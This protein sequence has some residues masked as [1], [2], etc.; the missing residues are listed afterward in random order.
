MSNT[1]DER[2]VQMKFNNG[3]FLNG[4]KSTLAGLAGLKKGLN[5]D[6]ATKGLDNLNAAGKRF[7]LAGL[8][9]GIEN[10][11]SKFSALSVVGIT[12]LATIANKAVNVGAQ[13]TK[14][15]TVKP[16]T[17]GLAEYETNLN[18]IQTIL[19]NTQA[20]GSTLADVNG[21]LAELN[22]YSDQTIYNF[23]EMAKNIGTFTAAGVDLDTST[24]AIKGIANLAALSGSNSNQAS[25]A[26]YQLSQELANGK[27]TLLGWTSVVNAGMGGTVFQRA[28]AET[29]VAMGTIDK[30]ALSLEGKMKNV[31]IEGKSFR[32]S[33]SAENGESWLTSE[34]LTQ[35]LQ[36]FTGDLSDAELAAE[37]FSASQ[38]EAI[39][40]QAK[41]AKEAATVVK[42]S[43]QLMGTLAE[44]AGS[45]W[46][47]SWQII[48]GDFEE[49]K[50]L[51][52]GVN[53]VLGEMIGKSADARNATL[54]DWKDSG[55]RD[56]AINAV[57]NAFKALM[58]VFTPIKEAFREIFP[59]TTG[60]QLANITK[61]I[62]NFTKGLIIGSEASDKL[63]RTFKGLFAILDIVKTVVFGLVSVFFEMLGVAT[64]GSGGILDFTAKIG[65][66]LVKVRDA[67]KEGDGLVTFFNTLRDV[68]RKPIEFI[69]QFATSLVELVSGFEGF[70][71][72]GVEDG[73][74]RISARFDVMSN[75]GRI[76]KGLW[77]K[78]QAA[79]KSARDFFTPITD[80]MMA[81]F[82]DIGQQIADAFGEVDF[83]TVLD[84]INTGLLAGIVLLI[85]KFLKGGFKSDE[86]GG[87]FD[88][89]KEA[90]GSLT[91]TLSAMQT[92]LK[93]ATLLAIAAAVALLTASVVAL[94][95]IDSA[96]LTK[97]LAAI[98]VMFVQ[99]LVGMGFLDAIAASS[100]FL[101]LPFIA[102]S[103][104]LLATAVLVL[105]AA[106]K[107]LSDLD[108][109]GLIKGLVG[110]SVLLVAV[111]GASKIMSGN[112]GGMISAGVG[113]IAVAAAIKI[114]ASA[115]KDFSALSWEDMA[116]GLV[117][118]GTVLTALTL[119]T[120]LAAVNKGAVASSVGLIL[121]GGALKVMAS[122][123]KDFAEMDVAS[124]TKGLVSVT[125]ILA[126]IA[127]FTKVTSG[128]ISMIATAAGVAILGGALKILASAVSDFADMSWADLGKGMAGM[129]A[130][131]LAI[132]GA[133]WLMP[134]NMIVT[135][136][137]LVIVAAALTTLSE[138]LT[139]MGGMSWEE[140]AKGLVTL[141]GSLLI[142]AG[143]MFLMTT[144]LPGALAL[145]VIAGALSLL[146]PV[147]ISL[148][149]MTWGEIVRG[150]VTLA[151]ALAII[152]LA[153]LLLTPVIPS[154]MGLGVAMAL[155][156]VGALGV[157]LGLVAFSAGLT[158]LALSGAV[159]TTVLVAMVSALLGLI[160]VAMTQFGLGVIALAGVITTGAPAIVGALVAVLTS[161]I[162]AILT[163]APMIIGALVTLIFMLIDTLVSNVPR[164]VAAGFELLLGILRGIGDN[165]GL[166][167][168]EAANIIVQ[169]INGISNN[170]PSITEA[171]A[172][173]II[174][175]VESLATSV[176]NNSSRMNA[177]GLD[178]AGAI[179]EG[180]TSGIAN[181]IAS[182]AQAARDMA[183]NAL[184]AAMDFLDI[185]SPSKKFIK[186]G[187]STGE[188][189]V[190]GIVAMTGVV[191]KASSDM[192]ATSLDGIKNSM[193]N[194]A[195]AVEGDLSLMP[196]VR[197]VLDLSNIR[198]GSNLINGMLVPDTLA[199]DKAYAKAAVLSTSRRAIDERATAAKA[200]QPVIPSITLNQTNTSP[201]ALSEIDIYRRTNN[202]LS[203]V[204]EVIDSHA[205]QS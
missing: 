60:A 122:S 44:A 52:T 168:D 90:F 181:G 106:V 42:T 37:G 1:I 135:A 125:A 196:T 124:L 203:T 38:I 21:K 87:F 57:A 101:K 201:K 32:D 72:G 177:A 204:K 197:P 69:R 59:A 139:S 143:A 138:V 76:A 205:R 35:T 94:S 88:S 47:A 169:F 95:F 12:A 5:L 93:S 150:L 36:Q 172:N 34:V 10:I 100:G 55:G 22:T 151:G 166:V 45:G 9:T 170:L 159:V 73:L 68:L 103:M 64:E 190:N 2:V 58:A 81:F 146:A 131:L 195:S 23:A 155:L 39:Q 110:V 147:L 65:D 152:G 86:G 13:I 178:L 19:A 85:R 67:I 41:T 20:S 89:I 130:A 171:G 17:D 97:A 7:S 163:I 180:M 127:L 28:L 162:Q 96:K 117:G 173:L 3:Q 83:S 75:L 140:I 137:S 82:G 188:G 116:K 46:A 84:M 107:N 113:M 184:S 77:E 175:F 11:S 26:M 108:W 92:T 31:Q 98:S 194:M 179:I 185:N 111:A 134:P 189:F 132:A 118:V 153:G 53:N 78:L 121:L 62:E 191:R 174:T 63:K 123:V 79:F 49:A 192:G 30:S 128:G 187:K 54:K 27:V 15:L 129:A 91:D 61:I 112:A 115:V 50:K 51:W 74:E 202:Q 176:R 161:L 198:K 126:A 40:Q 4:I 104:I 149:E 142:I 119:F 164:L 120:R 18:A 182:V 102:G 167:V 16:I 193:S 8:A 133:M 48:F 14:S 145:I 33:I 157:G 160:P 156:G 186:V 99:L 43:T 66:W 199:V 183:S 200:P 114:L 71:T 158:T 80:R 148:G 165:I 29:A 144:A 109:Q 154:L 70:D 56:A 141:A 24:S 105:S 25:Q 136:A 6:G